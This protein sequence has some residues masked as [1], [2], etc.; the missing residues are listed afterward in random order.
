MHPQPRSII[1]AEKVWASRKGA[2]T[3]IAMI[4]RHS[5]VVMAASGAMGMEAVLLTSTSTVLVR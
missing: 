4:G 5:E 3:L 2:S 1:P